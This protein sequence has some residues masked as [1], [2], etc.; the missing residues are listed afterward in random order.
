MLWCVEAPRSIAPAS[1]RWHAS[2][3]VGVAF[4][5]NRIKTETVCIGEGLTAAFRGGLAGLPAGRAR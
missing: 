3:S 5:P 1:I 2:P 4:E